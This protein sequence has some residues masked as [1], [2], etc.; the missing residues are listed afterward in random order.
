MTFSRHEF[1]FQEK[2]YGN[3]KDNG[4]SQRKLPEKYDISLQSVK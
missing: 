3:N 2:V 1:T 4:L